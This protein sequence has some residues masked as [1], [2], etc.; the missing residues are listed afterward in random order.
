MRTYNKLEHSNH[1]ANNWVVISWNPGTTCNYNCSYCPIYLHDGGYK[2]QDLNTVKDFISYCTEFYHPKKLYIEYGGGETTVWSNLIFI[3]EHIQNL[4]NHIGILTNASRTMRW[5]N[6]NK[7]KFNSIGVS[8]H[9]ETADLDHIFNVVDL[10]RNYCWTR[11]NILMHNEKKYWDKCVYLAEKLIKLDNI[12]I[13]LKPVN[14]QMIG[15]LL[16]YSDEQMEYMNQ[17]WNNLLSNIEYTD[18]FIKPIYRSKMNMVKNETVVGTEFPYWFVVN[19]KNNWKGWKCWSGVEQISVDPDGEILRCKSR[20]G[21]SL[22]NIHN[23]SNINLPTE[24]VICDK[25]LCRSSYDIASRKKI[26]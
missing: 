8:F 2:W 21:G 22:G 1:I 15:P 16:S 26:G 9:S 17:Q 19:K 7:N 12:K 25:L 3:A 20:V 14:D 10:M 13:V 23:L 11:V 4:G 6:D 5:W 24:P 18:D